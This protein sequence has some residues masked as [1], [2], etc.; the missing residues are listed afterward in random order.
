MNDFYR[1]PQAELQS[2]GNT[3]DT[4]A[5]D[6]RPFKVSGIGIA[7]LLGSAVAGGVLLYLNES[8]R[9]D[10]ARGLS[11]LGLS[12]LILAIA[13]ALAFALPPQVPGLLFHLG[14]MLVMLQIGSLNQG[15][16][17]QRHQAQG[18][19]LASNWKAVGLSILVML[20]LLAILFPAMLVFG[21]QRF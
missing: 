7:S 14:Q 6:S 4:F 2:G 12:V 9:G 18:H 16:D 17:L 11:L 15:D 20:A 10:T 19:A 8:K 13:I 3:R 21:P 1:T 5:A